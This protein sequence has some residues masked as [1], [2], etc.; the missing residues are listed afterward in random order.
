MI[1][2]FPELTLN[3]DI[4][5][6]ISR[7]TFFSKFDLKDFSCREE[8]NVIHAYR[9]EWFRQLDTGEL[10][11]IIPTVSIVAGKTQFI[12]GR[13]RT[14]V[15]LSYLEEV[16]IA[17]SVE[18]LYLSDQKFIDRIPKRPMTLATPIKLPELPIY[19]SI[20]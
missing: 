7:A 16:P 12:N 20:L 1:F 5:F 18:H 14:A 3:S 2:C 17:F 6:W 10:H 11:F 4:P 9:S 13:H 19:N 15:L 8:P